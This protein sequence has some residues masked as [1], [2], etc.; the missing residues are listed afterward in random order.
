[1]EYY[2][3]DEDTPE[4]LGLVAVV[5]N[6]DGNLPAFASAPLWR[7]EDTYGCPLSLE[8]LDFTP[9][10]YMDCEP[11]EKAYGI[12]ETMERHERFQD[13]LLL[14]HMAPDRPDLTLCLGSTYRV[15]KP[16]ETLIWIKKRL[17]PTSVLAN[18]H[19]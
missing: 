16:G 9:F 13:T 12:F 19:G 5:P 1:M 18:T 4:S 7:S 17:N 10:G 8:N 15:Y 6:Q 11:W 3:S 2:S 14:H